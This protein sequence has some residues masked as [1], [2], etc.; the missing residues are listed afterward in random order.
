MSRATS[1]IDLTGDDEVVNEIPEMID[2]AKDDSPDFFLESHVST[3]LKIKPSSSQR[4]TSSPLQFRPARSIHS[5]NKRKRSVD[6]ADDKSLRS[7]D[8]EASDSPLTSSRRRRKYHGPTNTSPKNVASFHP[9]I[10]RPSKDTKTDMEAIVADIYEEASVLHAL[11]TK[12]ILMD[13]SKSHHE[14]QED[15]QFK[16]LLS[17]FAELKALEEKPFAGKT[18]VRLNYSSKEK[19]NLPVLSVQSIERKVPRF[20]YYL[21]IDRSVLVEDTSEMSYVPNLDHKSRGDFSDRDR[22]KCLA[23]LQNTYG[24]TMRDQGT[25][26]RS[27]Q[28]SKFADYLE[29]I[30]GMSIHSLFYAY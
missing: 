24:G 5:L 15:L 2:L 30:F 4:N 25:T 8:S 23:E 27:E 29:D 21:E 7:P 18:V 19:K 1:F 11:A 26:W 16:D 10:P 22:V 20:K 3:S 12:E 28:A 17:P 6:F 13:G 14:N 9:K